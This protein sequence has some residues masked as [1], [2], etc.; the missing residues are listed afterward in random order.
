MLY[1][2]SS[3]FGLQASILSLSIP[4]LICIEAQIIYTYTSYT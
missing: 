2:I 1:S 3:I 4:E